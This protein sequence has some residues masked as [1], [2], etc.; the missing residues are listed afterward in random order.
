[1][2]QAFFEDDSDVDVRAAGSHRED[3]GVLEFASMFDTLHARPRPHS[4]GSFEGPAD[5]QDDPPA[6]WDSF[7]ATCEKEKKTSW[8]MRTLGGV[9]VH[10]LTAWALG[11]SLGG[12]SEEHQYLLTHTVRLVLRLAALLHYTASTTSST[13]VCGSSRVSQLF[14]AFLVFL[15]WD[16]FHPGGQSRLASVVELT[17]KL[18]HLLLS[19]LP[20]AWPKGRSGSQ[21]SSQ[22]ISS[23]LRVVRQGA[24]SL[25]HAY[26]LQQ[27]QVWASAPQGSGKDRPTEL[28]SSDVYRVPLLQDLNEGGTEF[29]QSLPVPQRPSSR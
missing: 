26:T 11:L 19:P 24:D 18:A 22:S 23:A 12:A 20:D 6:T 21:F 15:S 17:H 2:L 9:K 3:G 10:L 4:T 29:S 28:W 16:A 14:S 5:P 27:R 13:G 8:S 1:L 7:S 25:D